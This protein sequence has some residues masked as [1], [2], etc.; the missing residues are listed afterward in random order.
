MRPPRSWCVAGSASRAAGTPSDWS[1][2]TRTFS[3]ALEVDLGGLEV[4]LEHLPGHTADCAVAWIPD[5]GVLLAGDTVE[6]PLPVVNDG[7]MV[8]AWARALR[9]WAARPGLE[10]VVP[11]H[12][13][14][15][16]PDV[17]QETADYLEALRTGAVPAVLDDLD[18]FYART[19]RENLLQ[20]RGR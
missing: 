20:M 7:A 10:L 13:R 16:G 9:G 15:G 2:P 3:D 8:D 4:H 5:W 12:G 19:H 18:A 17:V 1:Q 14:I 6:T 11:S